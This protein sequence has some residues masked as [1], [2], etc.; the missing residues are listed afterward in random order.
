MVDFLRK[1]R[2]V[3]HKPRSALPLV[4]TGLHILCVQDA[5]DLLG[6]WEESPQRGEGHLTAALFALP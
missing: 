6:I 4:A 3:S 2:A 1:C 5:C